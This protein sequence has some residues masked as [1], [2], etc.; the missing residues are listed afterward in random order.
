[1][2]RFTKYN[3]RLQP[4]PKKNKA[5]RIEWQ[6]APDVD[7]RI[8]YLTKSLDLDWLKKD[9]IHAFRSESSKTKAYARIWGTTENMAKGTSRRALIY[10]RG[11]IGKI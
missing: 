4:K 2:Q 7:K 5:A 11:H 8:K 10:N 1:M 6:P 3:L 9:K